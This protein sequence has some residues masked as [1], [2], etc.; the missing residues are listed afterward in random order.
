MANKRIDQLPINNNALKDT[1]LIPIW[2]VVNSKTEK[3]SLSSL[4][5]FIVGVSGDT[6][7]KSGI[8]VSSASTI[9]LYRNDDVII[10]ISGITTSSTF[11]GNTS[12]SC[13]TNLYVTNLYGCS[14]ITINNSIQSITSSATGT[15]SFAFGNQVKAHGNYSH[16]EGKDT[17]TSGNYSHAEGHGTIAVGQGD[18]AEG[19]ETKAMGGN[20]HAEGGETI[21][22]GDASHAEGQ[23]TQATRE[24]SHAEGIRTTAS[25]YGSHS[26]GGD[27]TSSNYFSHAEGAAT[28]A[29]GQYSHSE[30]YSTI[31]SGDYSHAEGS[32]TT[33]SGYGS[34][35]G[36][37]GFN[38]SNRII[39][40]GETSFVHFRQT[41]ASG[42]IGAY[43]DYSAILG[44]NNHN[45]GAGST[46]SGI[47]AGSGNTINNDVLRSVVIG[48]TSIIASQSNTVYVPNLNI[49]V[50]YTPTSSGD[51]NGGIGSITWDDSY[52]YIKTNN[53][54]G[55]S[56]LDYTF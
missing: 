34:H 13:I 31:A 46:S 12:A 15:T 55:R 52:I 53:G 23:Q 41:S 6:Y 4:S 56:S 51:T 40:S 22:S 2:D 48:G 29:S 1:D 26:E 54:W 45:I 18:H 25:G 30:G 44:G 9:N 47:F 17:T 37:Q 36:G 21:A 35:S 11:T 42:T 8:Y 19:R 3:V 24:G 39:A 5:S 27:T 20:S 43:G 50:S 38:G 16:A 28:I 10:S 32:R 14:P 33:T 7:I 49:T